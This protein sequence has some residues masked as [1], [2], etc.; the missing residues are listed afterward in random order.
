V[1]HILQTRPNDDNALFLKAVSLLQSKAYEESIAPF[2][3]LLN[4]YTNNYAAQLNRAIAYLQLGRLDAARRDYEQVAKALPRSYQAWFGL[5]EIA[6]Q[7]KD[8]PAAITNY[9]HY[10]T[11]APPDTQEAKLVAARLKELMRNPP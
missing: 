11:N 5:A 10:L 7:Q 4:L 8:I 2:T 6:Y 1:D 9:Q 3:Y